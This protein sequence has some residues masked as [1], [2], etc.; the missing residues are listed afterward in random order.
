MLRFCFGASGAGK[1]TGL[2]KE[3]IER[4]MKERDTDFLILVPDQFTMQTQKDVVKMHPLGAI[5][6]IDI[7]SF[8]RLSHRVFEETGLSSFSVLDDLGKSLV[9]RRLS[10]KLGDRLPVIGKNMHK[11]GY[12]D[13]VKSTISEF[14]QYGIGDEDLALLEEKS[15]SKGALSA[16]LKDLRLLYREFLEYINGKFTTPEETLDILCRALPGSELIKDSVVVFDGFTGFT[17]IQYRVIRQL[18]TLCREV[19]V[20]VTI[21]PEEDPYSDELKEQEL[22]LLSKKTVLELE[23]LEFA[24]MREKGSNISD[25]AS[26][27]AIR[28]SQADGGRD[29][30]IRETP[31]ARLK[32]NPPLAYLEQSLFRY[33]TEKFSGENNSITIFR[34]STGDEEIRQA[35][36]MINDLVKQKGYAYRDIALLCGSLD[37]YADIVTR[38]SEKFGIPIYVDKN[39]SILLNPSME[40]ITSAINIVSSGYRYEFGFRYM[41]S[42]GTCLER[43]GAESREDYGR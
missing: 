25:F 41:R 22:F 6:N 8:G 2:Y 29:I 16:K 13:E 12:I 9:L 42:G 4:S 17:P 26:F 34:A 1:S 18:L 39:T 23:K 30:F 5:M 20:S 36:I 14:M 15:L 24:V 21:S 10:D 37:S 33:K 43:D 32:G 19:I 27:R 3:I 11:P 38:Q 40:Y 28:H 31:V 7:L 35:M